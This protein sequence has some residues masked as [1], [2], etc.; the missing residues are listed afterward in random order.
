MLIHI[1]I[2]Q[3]VRAISQPYRRVPIPL[4]NKINKKLDELIALDIIEEVHGPAE[5]ISP[6]VPVLKENGDVR[7]C[8]DMR[9]ANKAIFRENY[10]IPT[11]DSFLPKFRKAQYF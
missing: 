2:D 1:P 5:W 7:I 11:M 6:M 9:Q 3:S 10:P 8:I 4:E